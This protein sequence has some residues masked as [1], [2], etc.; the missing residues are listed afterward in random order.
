M[1]ELAFHERNQLMKREKKQSYPS[2]ET[3]AWMM[4][5]L[6]EHVWDRENLLDLGTRNPT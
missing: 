6:A 5:C 3:N 4:H 1:S 2:I